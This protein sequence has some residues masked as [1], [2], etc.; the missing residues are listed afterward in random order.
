MD[1]TTVFTLIR[2]GETDDNHNA[3]LQGQSNTP[4]NEAG[5]AQAR[6]VAERL[7]LEGP[8][9]VF[10]SSDLSRAMMT[11]QTISE[12]ISLPVEPTTALREWHLGVLEQRSAKELW[13][14][15]PD[16]MRSFRQSGGDLE[17]PGGESRRQF[18]A[19]VTGFLNQVAE[20]HHGKHVLFV[21]HGGVLRAIFRYILSVPETVDIQP[22]VSNTAFSRIALKPDGWQLQC[23]N[24]TFHLHSMKIVELQA[25]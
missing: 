22:Q 4:L 10:Y 21:T 15:Y 20:K 7:K 1:D 16:I 13:Q 8:F 12:A 24:D 23:W 5:L 9:D 17:I 18:R 14:E 2:H 6:L 19:R 25:Y 3:V 11:A